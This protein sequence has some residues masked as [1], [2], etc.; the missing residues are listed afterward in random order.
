MSGERVFEV[1]F[2]NGNVTIWAILPV[3]EVGQDDTEPVRKR[4]QT[5]DY[6][7]LPVT[8]VRIDDVRGIVAGEQAA[9]SIA[10]QVGD[11][12]LGVGDP[13]GEAEHESD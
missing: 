13:D 10:L 1:E 12:E 11:V 9:D 5:Y 8:D 6:S 3:P 7:E 4:L 2:H